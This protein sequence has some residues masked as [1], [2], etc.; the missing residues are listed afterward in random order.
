MCQFHLCQLCQCLIKGMA[1]LTLISIA[2]RQG[3]SDFITLEIRIS[4]I[5]EFYKIYELQ[6]PGGTQVHLGSGRSDWGTSI[7]PKIDP[8]YPVKSAHADK[9]SHNLFGY[10][11]I[12]MLV[13]LLDFNVVFRLCLSQC[14]YV[15]L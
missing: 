3:L 2:E 14:F 8:T 6:H 10:L 11:S 15:L 7:N 12:V 4:V 5:A 9:I 1:F 13:M